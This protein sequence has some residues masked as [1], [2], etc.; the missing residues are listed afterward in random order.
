VTKQPY[1]ST[2]NMPMSLELVGA[3]CPTDCLSESDNIGQS[4]VAV[5]HS[6]KDD[7]IPFNSSTLEIV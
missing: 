4:G 6:A 7:S 3:A 1:V 5:A 2:E